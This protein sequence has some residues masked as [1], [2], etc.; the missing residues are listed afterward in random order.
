MFSIRAALLKALIVIVLVFIR[1]A[2]SLPEE[3]LRNTVKKIA[4]HKDLPMISGIVKQI[5]PKNSCGLSQ[6]A[7]S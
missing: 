6:S 7:R 5:I 2:S 1:M 4:C 3:R